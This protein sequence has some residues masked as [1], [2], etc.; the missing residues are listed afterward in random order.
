MSLHAPKA[1]MEKLWI[2]IM[3]EHIWSKIKDP[4]KYQMEYPFVGSGPFQ[5]Q[6]W[7]TRQPYPDGQEPRLLGP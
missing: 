2:Y 4:E 1:N 6:E 7:K 3:P 5:C